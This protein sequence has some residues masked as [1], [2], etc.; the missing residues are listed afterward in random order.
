MGCTSSKNLF[1]TT[2]NYY[3]YNIIGNP[4]NKFPNEIIN[5]GIL[6]EDK[7]KNEIKLIKNPSIKLLKNYTDEELLNKDIK[8]LS[9]KNKSKNNDI[10]IK[11]I[12]IEEYNK[13]HNVMIV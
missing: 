6:I 13:I 4:S 10:N 8:I 9:T 12:F 2:N 3:Y 11:K 5:T 1:E 7:S